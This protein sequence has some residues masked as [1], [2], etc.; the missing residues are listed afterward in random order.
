MHFP[1]IISECFNSLST[2]ERSTKRYFSIVVDFLIAAGALFL[3]LFFNSDINLAD[4]A[5]H[6]YLF[7]FIPLSSV[8]IHYVVGVYQ[9]IIHL[10]DLRLISQLVK[11]SIYTSVVLLVLAYL[12]P[13]AENTPKSLFAVF[14]FFNLFGTVAFRLFWRS[15][16]DKVDEGIPVGI[17]GA[18]EAGQRLAVLLSASSELRPALFIDDNPEIDGT[19]ANGIQ[20]VSTNNDITRVK[21]QLDKRAIQRVIL[22]FPSA[23]NTV[24]QQRLAFIEKA[25]VSVQTLPSLSEIMSSAL[26]ASLSTEQIRDISITDILGR[27]EVSPDMSA[28]GAT[29]SGKVVLV[30]GGGGSIGS[31]I[32]RQIC[33]LNAQRLVIL[34]HSEE[35]LYEITEEITREHLNLNESSLEFNPILGSVTDIA[36]VKR[37]IKEFHVDTVFHAAAY[38]HVP[39]I[40]AQPAKGFETNVLGTLNVLDAAIENKISHFILISTDKAVRPTNAMGASKRVAELCLQARASNN[41]DTCIS[42]VRFGNVL[43]SSGSVVPKFKEQIRAGGPITITHPDITRYFMTI[44]EAAQLVLQAS[45]IAKGGDVFVLDMG[46][47]VKILDLAQT[48][49]RLSGRELSSETG[50]END[51]AIEFSGL[52]PGEKMFEELFIGQSHSETPISKVFTAAENKLGWDELSTELNKLRKFQDDNNGDGVRQVLLNLALFDQ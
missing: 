4:V 34:E 30:T 11:A 47:P 27:P 22:A 48:M 18:G 39:I 28:M 20:V 51:I 44:P 9:W 12:M 13:P 2:A 5:D 45:S 21:S 3:A 26:P 36:H 16:F 52:R 37:V 10:L 24:Y 7:F 50:D 41:L 8:L 49:V 38:K 46:E 15:Q 1:T 32:C 6:G 19:L 29:V 14:G 43:G 31:E 40:E 25:G 33:R 23:T 35:N 17:Y 42:M